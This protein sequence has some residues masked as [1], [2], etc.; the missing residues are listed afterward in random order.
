L[1]REE[2]SQKITENVRLNAEIYELKNTKEKDQL[3]LEVEK[4]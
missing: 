2:L 4:L 1:A 3:N